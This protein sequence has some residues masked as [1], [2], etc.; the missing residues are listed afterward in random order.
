MDINHHNVKEEIM[1]VDDHADLLE[2]LS[3]ILEN[4]YN[5]H[6]ATTATV[7]L[8]MLQQKKIDLIISDIMMEK[9]DGYEFCSTIKSTFAYSHIPVI[10]LTAKNTIQSKVEGLKKGAD[11]YI[12]KPFSPE[13]LIAQVESLL[14][15]RRKVKLFFTRSPLVKITSLA[16]SAADE[17]FLERLSQIIAT[18]L[19]NPNF[20]VEI[21]ARLMNTSRATLYRK[22]KIISDLSPHELIQLTRLK[23]TA[24]LLI[25]G[26]FKIYQVV[27]QVGFKSLESLSK[28]FLKQFG[29]T[30]SHFMKQYKE[31]KGNY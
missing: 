24:E 21:L 8:Q 7:A 28:S 6:S 20:D 13:Y 15:N 18:N 9:M 26:N 1:I 11:A 27:D 31:G 30:P 17:E 29:I 10:L 4:D 16:T 5:V 19:N 25:T 14:Y 2:F 23:K 22:I 12:E 3:E